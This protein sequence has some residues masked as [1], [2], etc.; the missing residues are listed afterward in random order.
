ML[1]L[2]GVGGIGDLFV[3]AVKNLLFKATS[4]NI[5]KEKVIK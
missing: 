5:E 2:F 4:P 3:T 1:L